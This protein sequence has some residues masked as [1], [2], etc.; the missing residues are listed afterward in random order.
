M[1]VD[2]RRVP[3]EAEGVLGRGRGPALRP[4][5]RERVRGALG[6]LRGDRGQGV[7]STTSRSSPPRPARRS[8]A[9]AR[10]GRSNNPDGALGQRRRAR[11]GR[12]VAPLELDSSSP[13][14]STRARTA[15]GRATSATTASST[16]AL[17]GGVLYAQS[18]QAAQ[19]G[20]EV[21][22]RRGGAHPAVLADHRRRAPAQHHRASRSPA[23][24]GSRSMR[25][26]AEEVKVKLAPVPPDYDGLDIPPLRDV[27]LHRRVRRRRAASSAPA[28]AV[29]D[30][31]LLHP[32]A[33]PRDRRRGSSSRSWAAR[34]TARA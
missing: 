12:G 29:R 24:R 3:R 25:S 31:G 8:S 19:G 1:Q 23:T 21:P 15:S 6:P 17:V 34:A 30:E 26:P 27:A 7:T 33:H 14:T 2:D 5:P 18:T 32:A 9:S 16:A 20:A 28:T 13:T 22:R 11:A 10:A 4:L